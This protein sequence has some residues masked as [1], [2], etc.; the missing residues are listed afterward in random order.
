LEGAPVLL[1]AILHAN[2]IGDGVIENFRAYVESLGGKALVDAGLQ[3]G[4]LCFMGVRAAP[5]LA[6][7]IATFSFLRG[8]RP[9]PVMR[10][11]SPFRSTHYFAVQLPDGDALN[12]HL[13]VAILDGG[14]P[15]SPDLSR[16]VSSNDGGDVDASLSPTGL[17]H[18]LAVTSAALFGSIE[19]GT[20]LGPPLAKIDH[21]RVVDGDVSQDQPHYYKILNRIVDVLVSEHYD[22]VNISVGPDVSMED[23]IIHAWTAKLDE[24]FS[25]GKTLA[26]HAAGNRGEESPP[27]S[28]LGPPADGVNAIGVGACDAEDGAWSKA[29]Y[30]SI[31]PGRSPGIIKPDV[32]SF[33][34]TPGAEFGALYSQPIVSVRG[35]IGTSFA[36]PNAMRLALGTA[37]YFGHALKPLAVKAL[38]V[39]HAKRD[40][41]HDVNH[42]GWG[43]VP[44]DYLKLVTCEP[45]TVHVVYQGVLQPRK[46]LRARIP[47]PNSF[48]SSRVE[49]TA[50]ICY[51]T[52]VE[53]QNPASYT[54]AGVDVFFRP[55]ATRRSDPQQRHPDTKAFF[56]ASDYGESDADLRSDALKWETVMSRSKRFQGTSLAD[57]VFDLHYVPRRDGGDAQTPAEI[58]Y[59]MVITVRQANNQRL[60]DDVVLR[61]RTQLQV[62]QPRIS[63]PIRV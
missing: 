36:S 14:L 39:H 29:S 11:Y 8:L 21:F 17:E 63:I 31:G 53:P 24:L 1:E 58:P 49:I 57:P 40:N 18:G 55:N 20:A 4:G 13:R 60:Y 59:G 62:L 22:Y 9:M 48:G 37:A 5:E 50:T 12:P 23:D 47:V 41:T 38:L 56:R 6:P 33:G 27:Q 7:A 35:A 34:G 3:V 61:Y 54:R 51:A 44:N 15:A 32:V 30:S 45:N 28:R 10:S 2:G 43:R 19:S 16:W 52:E 46:T 42:V 26:F 25:H